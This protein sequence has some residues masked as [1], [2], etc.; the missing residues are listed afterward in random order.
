ME[1]A[2]GDIREG[3]AGT[4]K[5]SKVYS[6]PRTTLQRRA[7]GNNKFATETVKHLG[8]CRPTF[9]AEAEKELEKYLLDME[10]K[11]F[12]LTTADV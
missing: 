2:L 4:L 1:K 7:R 11:F 9:G 3:K 12:G 5:A 8:S 10:T 6:V